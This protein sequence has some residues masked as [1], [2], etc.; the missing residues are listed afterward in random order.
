[1]CKIVNASGLQVSAVV[2]KVLKSLESLYIASCFELS[3]EVAWKFR[4]INTYC[5]NIKN[6]QIKDDLQIFFYSMV[7]NETYYCCSST[8][9]DTLKYY[10]YDTA[11]PMRK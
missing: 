4:D 3:K 10:L 11:L 2:Q 8:I 6:L 5:C 1:M 7:V 9:K